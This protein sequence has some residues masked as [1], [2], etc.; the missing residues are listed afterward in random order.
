[1]GGA[2]EWSL[3]KIAITLAGVILS[4]YAFKYVALIIISGQFF[5]KHGLRIASFGLRSGIQRLTFT[6]TKPG[7]GKV[8]LSRISIDKIQFGILSKASILNLQVEK[9]VLTLKAADDASTSTPTRNRLNLDN[10]AKTGLS[11]ALSLINLGVIRWILKAVSACVKSIEIEFVDASGRTVARY[12]QESISLSFRT[13]LDPGPGALRSLCAHVLFAPF[14]LQLEEEATSPVLFS[15]KASTVEAKLVSSSLFGISRPHVHINVYGLTVDLAL[16]RRFAGAFKSSATPANVDRSPSNPPNL[17]QV[18]EQLL[19]LL[20]VFLKSDPMLTLTLSDT[21]LVH[22]L[23]KVDP[24]GEK[25]AIPILLGVEKVCLSAFAR[26]PDSQSEKKTASYSSILP[27]EAVATLVVKDLKADCCKMRVACLSE[28]GLEASLAK[29]N[30]EDSRSKIL[31]CNCSLSV[32]QLEVIPNDTLVQIL[33][34]FTGKPKAAMSADDLRKEP[35]FSVETRDQAIDYLRT[36]LECVAFSG[37]IRFHLPRIGLRMFNYSPSARSLKD[38]VIYLVFSEITL[39]YNNAQEDLHASIHNRF[40]DSAQ[41]DL[42]SSLGAS[43]TLGGI[44]FVVTE[45]EKETNLNVVESLSGSG[46]LNIGRLQ[47]LAGAVVSRKKEDQSSPLPLAHIVS[48]IVNLNDTV[49]DLKGL[50]DLADPSRVDFFALALCIRNL[51]ERP[52]VEFREIA[53]V[54]SNESLTGDIM[55]RYTASQTSLDQTRIS[56]PFPPALEEIPIICNVDCEVENLNILLA[57]DTYGAVLTLR[58]FKVTLAFAQLPSIALAGSD[59]MLEADQTK[60]WVRKVELNCLVTDLLVFAVSNFNVES[61]S[62]VVGE[63]EPIAI[64]DRA[65]I[66]ASNK[67]DGSF[68]PVKV[69]IEEV[70]VVF[71]FWTF[72]A[73]IMSIAPVLKVVRAAIPI[74]PKKSDPIDEEGRLSRTHEILNISCFRISLEGSFDDRS[75]LR[76]TIESIEGRIKANKIIDVSVGEGSVQ[77]LTH[78]DPDKW[79]DLLILHG[80]TCKVIVLKRRVGSPPASISVKG[81]SASIYNPYGFLM[82][83]VFE[84][85]INASKGLK[86]VVFKTLGLKSASEALSSGRSKIS[87]EQIPIISIAFA[88]ISLCLFDSDFEAAISINYRKGLEEQVGRSAREKAFQKKA[89]ETLNISRIELAKDRDLSEIESAWWLLQEFNSKSWLEKIKKT[90]PRVKKPLFTLTIQ[91]ITAE[92]T[93]PNLPAPTIEESLHAIDPNTPNDRIYDELIPRKVKICLEQMEIKIR[94]Y[95]LPL[96]SIPRSDVLT[97]KTEGLLIFAEPST[98]REAKRVVKL[99]LKP[100]AIAGTDFV[101]VTRSVNPI[102]IY[103]ETETTIS[104]SVVRTN[105]GSSVEAPMGDVEADVFEQGYWALRHRIST[106]GLVAGWKEL[107]LLSDKV[108]KLT[109]QRERPLGARRVP[110]NEDTI[111]TFNG[112]VRIALGFQFLTDEQES[113]PRKTHADVLLRHPDFVLRDSNSQ[114]IDSLRGFR[115]SSIDVSIKIQVTMFPLILSFFNEYP[116]GSGGVGLRT[117]AEKMEVILC[118]RQNQGQ[119]KTVSSSFTGK[120][121]P[122]RWLLETSEIELSEAEGR[123]FHFGTDVPEERS[124]PVEELRKWLLDIDFDY[125]EDLRT[126]LFEPFVWSPKI[127]YYKRESISKPNLVRSSYNKIEILITKKNT[128]ERKIKDLKVLNIRNYV[129]QFFDLLERDSSLKYCVSSSALKT[130]LELIKMSFHNAARRTDLESDKVLPNAKSET[131]E[132]YPSIVVKGVGEDDVLKTLLDALQE[133]KLVVENESSSS[134]S[135]GFDNALGQ[136]DNVGSSYSVYTPSAVPQSLDYVSSSQRAESGYMIQL[137]NPQVNFISMRKED[138]ADVCSVLV[139]AENMLFRSIAI[140]SR[141]ES[142]APVLD[143]STRSIDLIKKRTILNVH[144]AQFFVAKKEDIET[145]LE[146]DIDNM[147]TYKHLYSSGSNVGENF[148]PLW[149]PPECLI[150]PQ[151][152][153]RYLQ[154]VVEQTSASFYRDKPNPLYVHKETRDHDHFSADQMDCIYINFDEFGIAMTSAHFAVL[155]DIITNLLVYKD[156]SRQARLEKLRKMALALEQVDDIQKFLETVMKLQ[157]KIR[158]AENVLKFGNL[159]L[160]RKKDEQAMSM[161]D[162][163]KS[164]IQYQDELYIIINT[165]KGLFNVASKKKSDD[166]TFKF[167]FLAKKIEWLLLDPDEDKIATLTFKNSRFLWHFREDQSNINTLEIDELKIE[168]MK[169]VPAGFKDLLAPLTAEPGNVDFHRNKM[170]RVYWHQLAAVAGIPVVDHF[171][172][173]FFPLT[174]QITRDIGRHLESYF[175]KKHTKTTARA[176]SMPPSDDITKPMILKH[177]TMSNEDSRSRSLD[178]KDNVMFRC[179][180]FCE[181]VRIWLTILFLAFAK[182]ERTL[183]RV[184]VDLEASS[185][186]ATEMKQVIMEHKVGTQSG[187]MADGKV[188]VS[189]AMHQPS[190]EGAAAKSLAGIKEKLLEARAQ[191]TAAGSPAMSSSLPP[192]PSPMSPHP[193]PSLSSAKPRAGNIEASPDD[194]VVLTHSKGLAKG[195]DD[196]KPS[197]AV[198]K[199]TKKKSAQSTRPASNTTPVPVHHSLPPNPRKPPLATVVRQGGASGDVASQ[200]VFTTTFNQANL[201]TDTDPSTL[202]FSSSSAVADLQSPGAS[203]T[204]SWTRDVSQPLP[205]ASQQPSMRVL[206]PV[207]LA[208]GS[209]STASAAAA[210]LFVSRDQADN[211]IDLTGKKSS[212][213]SSAVIDLTSSPTLPS[214][215]MTKESRVTGA[216]APVNNTEDL[217][218][219]RK[220]MAD[221]RAQAA[222]ANKSFSDAIKVEPS[223][224]KLSKLADDK[225][226]KPVQKHSLEAPT[227]SANDGEVATSNEAKA[228][229]P[230]I[231]D[232]APLDVSAK[233]ES[234]GETANAAVRTAK[235]SPQRSPIS[236]AATSVRPEGDPSSLKSDSVKSLIGTT[237]SGTASPGGTNPTRVAPSSVAAA[238][239]VKVATLAPKQFASTT[240]ASRA[241]SNQASNPSSL[242]AKFDAVEMSQAKGEADFIKPAEPLPAVSKMEKLVSKLSSVKNAN[243][244]PSGSPPIPSSTVSSAAPSALKSKIA[245]KLTSLS[246]ATSQ[247]TLASKNST[248]NAAQQ[249]GGISNM[250][251]TESLASIATST[252]STSFATPTSAA[253]HGGPGSTGLTS[254][255]ISSAALARGMSSPALSSASSVHAFAAPHSKEDREAR[256]REAGWPQRKTYKELVA[257]LPG[258]VDVT[259]EVLCYDMNDDVTWEE[260][261]ALLNR[262]KV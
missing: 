148:W 69:E 228:V 120:S 144:K 19:Q 100:L 160:Q 122:T 211:V 97:W 181:T 85:I 119:F 94:D 47:I 75:A 11:P 41:V 183:K 246:E 45:V 129:F 244:S 192:K 31:S 190:E 240:N 67:I 187:P 194:A 253:N 174:L 32:S 245:A 218:M 77:A 219:Y 64:V 180:G 87:P 37:E 12:F 40:I 140:L 112:G 98:S 99:S 35:K 22:A 111:A 3:V 128:I 141:D 53:I 108:Y 159:P 200:V 21:A 18:I 172:I 242:N 33:L 249:L 106:L 57:Q 229:S 261:R 76:G 95:P 59:R 28:V 134:S 61:Y 155:S 206:P 66:S 202:L 113:V 198:K 169:N 80:V 145:E 42:T 251:S 118:V 236:V 256:V 175:F 220:M 216:R 156:P 214:R 105:W 13:E 117:R 207:P 20:Q 91:D 29:C 62:P 2:T 89:A 79:E 139:A 27:T 154:R 178:L 170:L 176:A 38:A 114:F 135:N 255:T 217:E 171:E 188:G 73:L 50:A 90:L 235:K 86:N 36:S 102:K 204:G 55:G 78:T 115:T 126:I 196:A 17:S 166:V 191:K 51:V 34:S 71:T 157:E 96:V 110:V 48:C 205:T 164:L 83:Q 26:A 143:T 199:R 257:K 1:M 260:L 247:S 132:V 147:Y 104:A 84:N 238:S 138:E 248:T 142:G 82:S 10:L 81:H 8:H 184:K 179:F 213:R 74:N 39:S 252:S 123:V 4:Y 127:V 227:Q 262:Y 209:I 6:P 193:I 131:S 150:D 101:T 167:E 54:S 24:D 63:R 232:L 177:S 231:G 162:V 109:L 92:A 49:I 186:Q 52:P 182:M 149:A 16:C 222:A 189:A 60:E 173:N 25:I 116:D 259:T 5:E 124:A 65:A 221:A 223:T 243:I 201:P 165:M 239:S 72:Y 210:N 237:P 137:I 234:M 7:K 230:K 125:I 23:A 203:F 68:P 258:G 93:C 195:V 212:L 103:T 30:K 133:G 136:G 88:S 241:S 153:L 70:R 146:S 14:E 168:A 151:S 44:S 152:S 233:T 56:K 158:T 225:S 224:S 130:T 215:G 254:R 121:K 46:L 43:L 9:L 226:P 208:S 107:R 15:E 197:T 163:R 250:G 161:S 185:K 58:S